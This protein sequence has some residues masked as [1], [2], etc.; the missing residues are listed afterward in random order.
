LGV[1]SDIRITYLEAVDEIELLWSAFQ[2]KDK[3]EEGSL[4]LQ[5]GYLKERL[6]ALEEVLSLEDYLG[7]VEECLKAISGLAMPQWD[8][9]EELEEM[10]SVI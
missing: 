2:A 1:R 3:R 5:V 6:E 9:A 7:T 8:K 10:L 4:L